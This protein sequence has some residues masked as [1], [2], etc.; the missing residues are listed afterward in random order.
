MKKML[1]GIRDELHATRDSFLSVEK[2]LGGSVTSSTDEKVEEV[3]RSLK[4]GMEALSKLKE[5]VNGDNKG[6]FHEYDGV[7]MR[8]STLVK[9]VKMK[10][11]QVNEVIS[12]LKKEDVKDEELNKKK[13]QGLQIAV[14]DISHDLENT[15]MAFDDMKQILEAINRYD[16][17]GDNVSE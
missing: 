3:R 13:D 6:Q 10:L 17:E 8:T 16:P 14:L 2:Y 1:V 4:D 9:D 7:D 15:K 12:Q 5:D 11:K